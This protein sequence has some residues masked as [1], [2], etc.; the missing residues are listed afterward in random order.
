MKLVEQIKV[1]GREA[2]IPELNALAQ[3]LWQRTLAKDLSSNDL[4]SLLFKP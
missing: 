4:L 1:K 3:T 2:M